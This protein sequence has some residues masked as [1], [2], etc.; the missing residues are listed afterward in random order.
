MSSPL[1]HIVL[2]QN[3]SFGGHLA[4]S[5]FLTGLVSRYQKIDACYTL[6]CGKQERTDHTTEIH[7]QSMDTAY[8]TLLGN[9]LFSWR[10][11]FALIRAHRQQK[12]SILHCFYPHSSL[13]AAVCFKY[14]FAKHAKIIYDIR[15]P[16]IEM[17]FANHHVRHAK[18]VIKHLMHFIEKILIRFVDQFVWITDWVKS[19]YERMYK[20]S[21]TI[22]AAIIPTGV[23]VEK[24]GRPC[25]DEERSSLRKKLSV[26][27]DHQI[28]C[29][30]G[31]ISKMRQMSSFLSSQASHIRTI[32]V[33]FVM[34]W[35]GDDLLPMQQIVQEMQLTDQFRFLGVLA[36]AEL[37]AYMQ[38]A[39]IGR[40]HL[41]DIFVFQHSF[42][43]KILEYLAAWLPVLCSDIAAHR[44]IAS[45]F[46]QEIVV[47]TPE[48]F[49][50]A[51]LPC[52]RT[53]NPHIREYDRTYLYRQY[54]SIYHTLL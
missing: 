21:P 30:V 52:N 31:T 19:Y 33:T 42:P 23:D 16:R 44:A 13:I 40:C 54:N 9:L 24:F 50:T 10:A 11:F 14:L 29:Y 17:S 47:Y 3:T 49:L 12:I 18:R 51:P 46:P 25:S 43:L 35:W 37:V 1:P 8:N 32:P 27:D 53:Q 38:I 4:L 45:R 48:T 26:P 39:D 28:I 20:I 34:I 5:T 2:I 15:S 6:F 7:I 22:P 41:P 36:Q